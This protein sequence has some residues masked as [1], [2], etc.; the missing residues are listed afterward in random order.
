MVMNYDYD[1]EMRITDPGYVVE[2][3]ME[4]DTMRVAQEMMDTLS[5]R[6][7][8]IVGR[9]HFYTMQDMRQFMFY[10]KANEPI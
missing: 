1:Y 2:V 9:L 4:R 10:W 3:G 6:G 5:I 7:I 8:A